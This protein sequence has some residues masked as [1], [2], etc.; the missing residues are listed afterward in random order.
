SNLLTM[1]VTPA[2]RRYPDDADR[3][4][5][6]QRV[7][8]RLRAIP[9][10][11]AVT[12]AG[13]LPMSGAPPRPLQIDRRSA[14]ARGGAGAGAAQPRVFTTVV[15]TGYFDTLNRPVLRGR[16]FTWRDGTTG[17]ANANVI[18]NQRFVELFLR[19]GDA[20][21]RRI[22]LTSDQR[23]AGAPGGP[24]SGGGGGAG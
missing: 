3:L 11:A 5:F 17:D 6:Y 15:A 7:E 19:E 9:A 18:V 22:R 12:L 14:A 23:R 1:W 10:I 24:G 16:G 2:P 13:S 4:A 21:G 8:E 20:I